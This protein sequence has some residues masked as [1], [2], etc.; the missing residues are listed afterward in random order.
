[1]SISDLNVSVLLPELVLVGVAVLVMLVDILGG[2][3]SGENDR[4]AYRSALPWVALIGV[5]ITE[6]LCFLQ[7]SQPPA[8]F[9]TAAISDNF[10]FGVRLIVLVTTG[11]TICLSMGYISR[12]NN[13]QGEYY[14]L[15][16]LCAVGMMMMGT[17]TD[18][19]VVFI[20]LEIF[21]LSLYIL[22]GLHRENERSSEASMK[23]FLLGAFASA[24]FVYGAALI[25]GATG[26]TQYDQIAAMLASGG[27]EITLLMF[28]I[29][30]LIV[31][32]GFKVSLVPFHMWTPDV[33]QGAPTPITA[34]MSV[35]T[36]TATFAAFVRVFVVALPDYQET[37][38]LILAVLAILTMTLG[39]LVAL[40]QTSLKR[41][42]AY[43]SIAHAGYILVG[44][45]PG[46]TLGADAALFYLFSYA[47]TNIGAFAVVMMLEKVT[48]DTHER[49]TLANRARGLASKYPLLAMAMAIFM[50]GLS[51]MPPMA[52]FF[53]K[54]FIF[55]AA[56]EGGWAWLAV[57]AVLNS[58][59]GAYY[60]LR[61]IMSM[62]L[63]DPDEESATTIIDGTM[64]RL[65]VGIAAVGT[66]IV[67]I[68]PSYWFGLFQ[69]S[70]GG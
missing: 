67:G 66:L 28:G 53:G 29:A 45:T 58:A 13:K 2:D 62:Y 9:Q 64:L 48:E 57:I 12:I 11:L 49:D 20:A 61:V 43:S 42:L 59:I 30:L 46:T 8:Y 24:F 54:F 44:L 35:G 34:F 19:I 10:A 39:N 16:L 22:T 55:Q 5:G 52:G 33:Y 60:Y 23:Y 21:S 56:V 69:A 47:F 36:K 17:A 38:G 15:L 70:L 7:W 31:G 27:G 3:G 18:L 6:M 50:F 37:W 63:R 65:G 1:M 41:L 14:A 25:Y 4:P 32:F 68:F 51:G 26:S 40:R